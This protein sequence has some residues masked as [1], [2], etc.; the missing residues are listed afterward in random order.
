[1]IKKK[2]YNY[3][4]K[5]YYNFFVDIFK[6]KYFQIL[7]S[8]FCHT[9]SN[10]AKGFVIFS[11]ISFVREKKINFF[12]Y[13]MNEVDIKFFLIFLL[14]LFTLTVS[15]NLIS[16]KLKYRIWRDYSYL[17]LEEYFFLIKKKI[18]NHNLKNFIF[19]INKIG[20]MAKTSVHIIN[21]LT[22]SLFTLLLILYFE[23]QLIFFFLFLILFAILFL[24]F[25]NDKIFFENLSYD[26]FNQ[27]FKTMINQQAISN[28]FL[29]Q[30][31]SNIK[32]F[33]KNSTDKFYVSDLAKFKFLS[34]VALLLFFTI[35]LM[36]SLDVLIN[37]N[38][39]EKFSALLVI[40]IF[41]L[42]NLIKQVINSLR[43]IEYT[44]IKNF[45]N[46]RKDNLN[47]IEV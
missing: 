46:I 44:N 27:S 13:K 32:K 15:L 35:L 22:I 25:F 10:S 33:L 12:F 23:N 6:K 43:F 17:K 21:S 39:Y 19:S 45:P 30:N 16:E 38:N 37:I 11:T 3:L 4:T 5:L 8:L 20:I 7:T 14:T 42:G 2:N 47:D 24:L 28:H 26:E 9:I 31:C 41:N 34:L 36:V 29:E 40:L 1:M 18:N